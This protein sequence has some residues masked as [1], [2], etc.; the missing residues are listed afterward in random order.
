M[1][2]LSSQ[3]ASLVFTIYQANKLFLIG[4]TH[5]N[6]SSV[7]ERT[8][9]RCTGLA[10]KGSQLWMSNLYQLWRFENF[11]D[12]GQLFDGYDAIYVTVSGHTTGDIDIHHIHICGDGTPL[13]VNTRFNCLATLGPRFSFKPMW[14]PPFIDRIAV[15]DR[16]HLNGMAIKNN[17]ARYVTC[18]AKS[19]LAE[20]WRDHRTAGAS[21]SM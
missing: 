17:V 10:V 4:A 13:F 20:G 9:T 15:E 8:S 18:V 12:S 21:L 19:N 2:W 6:E 11:L 5:E 7:F 14:K 3:N 1:A 16:C